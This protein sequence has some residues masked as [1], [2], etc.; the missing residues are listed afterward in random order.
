MSK[1]LLVIA[2]CVGL[3]GSAAAQAPETGLKV[4]D[5]AP[6]F[7]LQGTDGRVHR[8][9]DYQGKAVVLAWYPKAS[10]QG[11]TI[12][13]KSLR[14]SASL[15]GQYDV[16]YFMASV[17][18]P[19]DNL[20]FARNNEANFPL[21]SDPGKETARAYGVLS[22]RGVANRWTFYIGPDGRILHVDRQVNPATAG[23]DLAE[24]LD[25]LKI[26]RR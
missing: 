26:A 2:L 12:E 4:G 8:L 16:V 17:D 24:R 25:A 9:S 5:K 6:D 19:E 3:A 23:Q 11:C 18:T 13:C 21:L 10:T 20:T 22:E 14:D 1:L 7:A 15:I